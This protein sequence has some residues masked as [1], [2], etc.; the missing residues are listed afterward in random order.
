MAQ[1]AYE[2]GYKFYEKPYPK[3]AL[4]G[5]QPTPKSTRDKVEKSF[6]LTAYDEFGM[7]ELLGPG[8]ACECEK[9]EGMH[10]WSDQ[11]YV[12]CIDPKTGERVPEGKEGELVWTFLVSEAMVVIR[13][14][15]GDLSRII[16]EPCACGRTSVRIANIKGR[17]DAG[18]SIGGYVIFPSTVE[19]VLFKFKESGSNFQCIVDSDQRGLDRLTLNLEASDRSILSDETKKAD[20]IKRLT[21]SVQS[22]LGVT[23]KVINLVEPDS[24][25][26]AK[27]DQSKT[28]NIRMIDKRK[29]A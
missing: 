10:V 1:L 20:F 24:L 6:G 23:P 27:D 2:K 7:T 5:G 21:E 22:Y 17:V 9:R 18:M 14:R 29:H 16:S 4:F 15:S 13:Y 25:P 19:D 12:E 26:V 3:I 8:M 28:S 11:I